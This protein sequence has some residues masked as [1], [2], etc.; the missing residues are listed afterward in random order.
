MKREEYEAKDWVP[1]PEKLFEEIREVAF[2]IYE[3]RQ[4]KGVPGDEVTDWFDA[5]AQ[6][7]AKHGL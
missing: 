3:A 5:E 4:A 6:V 2:Q 7:R 1:D